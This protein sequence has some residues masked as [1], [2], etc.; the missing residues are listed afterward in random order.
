MA[1]PRVVILIKVDK[2]VH[3]QLGSE[4]AVPSF[5]VLARQIFDYLNIPPDDV[6]LAAENRKPKPEG[7]TQ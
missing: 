4:V 3:R 5:G 2:P 1:S 6:R 7:N